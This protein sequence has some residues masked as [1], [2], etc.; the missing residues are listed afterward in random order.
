MTRLEPE[1]KGLVKKRMTVE[2]YLEHEPEDEMADSKQLSSILDSEAEIWYR[3]H[4]RLSEELF[5]FWYIWLKDNRVMVEG[6]VEEIKLTS[7]QN[8]EKATL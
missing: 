8:T 3:V 1:T 4:W 6:F 7:K 5:L 2:E